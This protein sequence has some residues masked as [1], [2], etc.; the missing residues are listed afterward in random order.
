MYVVIIKEA[1]IMRPL[2]I[3]VILYAERQPKE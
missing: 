2:L 3:Y 1:I